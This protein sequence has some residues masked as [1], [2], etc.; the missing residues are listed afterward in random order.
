MQTIDTSAETERDQQTVNNEHRRHAPV[1]VIHVGMGGWGRSWAQE[2]L[3]YPELSGTVAYVDVIPEMLEPLCDDLGVPVER[4]FPTLDAAMEAT[5]AEAVLVTTAL[6]GHAEVA[7]EALEAG[8][9]VL[10]EKP[11]ASSLEQGRQMVDAAER[12]GKTLMVS[13]QYRFYPAVQTAAGLVRDRVLGTVGAASVNFRKHETGP[14]HARHYAL[15][16]PLL[17]DMSIH[18]F[19]LMRYVLGREPIAVTCRS[20]NT[21]WAQF[22]E[23]ASAT[24][25]VEF[26][27]GI[28]VEYNGSWV[29]TAP[30]TL[31]A[32]QWVIECEDG[33]IEFTSRADDTIEADRVVLRR[34][35]ERP[36]VVQLPP[37]SYFDRAGSMAEFQLAL[38][39]GRPPLNNGASN[40]GSLALTFGAIEAAANGR[41]TLLRESLSTTK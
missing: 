33:V 31:W 13:Q 22:A 24:A 38:R 2:L 37:I 23:S 32:G 19:D 11:M 39:H 9:H 12:A 27:G 35:G 34:F 15:H 29:S 30:S 1:S 10:V 5:A 18:H 20:W 25:T 28:M 41:P 14:E 17:L 4:C 8:K 7:V 3:R 16:D 36:E 40:L 26:E 6:P 21:P